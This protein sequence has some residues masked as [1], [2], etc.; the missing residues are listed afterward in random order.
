MSSSPSPTQQPQPPQQQQEERVWSIAMEQCEVDL[1][2]LER[3]EF[4][5][6]SNNNKEEQVVALTLRPAS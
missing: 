1:I 2:G 3:F 5:D 6:D 4:A